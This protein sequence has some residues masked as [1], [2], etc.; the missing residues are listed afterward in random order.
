MAATLVVFS[1]CCGGLKGAAKE[2][3]EEGGFADS[4]GADEGGGF[5]GHHG[6][7]ELFDS[8]AD[9]GADGKDRG[10]GGGGEALQDLIEIEVEGGG[11]VGFVEEN[12]GAG[13]ALLGDD[14]VAL[15]AALVEVAIEAAD[16]E[17]DVDVGGEDLLFD[18]G[19]GLLAGE[20][21]F[22]FEDVFDDGRAG[23]E[24]DPVTDGWPE[25]GVMAEFAADDGFEF[26]VFSE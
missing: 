14:E 20:K 8:E 24:G 18:C 21:G 26:A 25:G 16:D 9:G 12:D 22:A 6:V 17:E 11:E 4:G 10:S 2:P 1:D 15:D 19:A 7:V 23:A 5:A 13:A 3:V